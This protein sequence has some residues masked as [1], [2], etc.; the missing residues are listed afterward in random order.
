MTGDC[1]YIEIHFKCGK[2]AGLLHLTL[3]CKHKQIK[4][5]KY[6]ICY[7]HVQI[8]QKKNE[9][10]NTFKVNRK[11]TKTTS[12]ASI[13]KF[14]QILHC[15][16]LLILLNSN[17][18]CW[19]G[20]RNSSF[21]QKIAFSNCE[22]YIALWVT[23]ICQATCFHIYSPKIS[24]EKDKFQKDFTIELQKDKLNPDPTYPKGNKEHQLGVPVFFFL[25]KFSMFKQIHLKKNCLASSR[26]VKFLA[27]KFI[28]LLII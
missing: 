23:K 26:E 6:S 19:L 24:L 1:C 15:I 11:N 7:L 18:K 17:K 27:G 12:G 21:R 14:G 9:V 16:L 5:I 8:Q 25:Q 10:P 13:V 22:K 2:V 4:A 3:K 20:L 28:N